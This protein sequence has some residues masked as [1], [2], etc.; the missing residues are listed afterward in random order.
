MRYME[1]KNMGLEIGKGV[2]KIVKEE[3]MMEIGVGDF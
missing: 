1:E 2:V 3:I